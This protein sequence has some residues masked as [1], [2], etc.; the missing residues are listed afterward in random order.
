MLGLLLA[1][2]IVLA[3][4]WIPLML[5]RV[6]FKLIFGLVFLPFQ[7]I[8]LVFRIVFGVVFGVL[9][10]A[11]RV[12]FSGAGLLALLVALVAFVIL[13]PLVPVLLVGLGLW[14]LTRRSR[15]HTLLRTTA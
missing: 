4:L 6:A 9:G 7:L 15:P 3:V 10:V 1:V 14:L 5:V 2:L 13:I 11:A 12:L 8:G